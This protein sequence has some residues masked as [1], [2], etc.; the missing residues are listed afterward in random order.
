MMMAAGD[1]ENGA[2]LT[3]YNAQAT[4]IR[5]LIKSSGIKDKV[6]LYDMLFEGNYCFAPQ[7]PYCIGSGWV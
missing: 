4:L 1:V 3:P 6:S 2:I 5:R 7:S